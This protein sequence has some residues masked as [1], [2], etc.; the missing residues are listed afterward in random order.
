MSTSIMLTGSLDDIVFDGRNQAYGAYQL[1][2]SYQRHL[3]SALVISLTACSL[4]FLAVMTA[5]KL[6]ADKTISDPMLPH[7]TE[8]RPQIYELPKIKP[9]P[10]PAAVHP[11]VTVVPHAAIKTQVAPDKEVKP[12]ADSKLLPDVG[13]TGPAKTG[14]AD[15]DGATGST[16][17]STGPR[18]DSARPAAVP[19]PAPV[20]YAEVMPDFV[21][22]RAAL[23]RYLQKHLR[24][25]AAALAAQVSGKVFVSFV[26]QTDGSIGEVTVLKGLG[27]GTE[28]AAAH[29]V[30]EMPAWTPGL[31]NRRAVPVRFTLPITFQFE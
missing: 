10:P 6:F 20:L 4:L 27:Y 30:R 22:G 21:G 29:V 18:S 9:T 17:L 8:S 11:A 25:P 26:V 23:Q 3:G 24:F 2:R 1:R 16:G 15:A 28:E 12:E 5:K 7:V 31:Q 14:V 13:P 19:A